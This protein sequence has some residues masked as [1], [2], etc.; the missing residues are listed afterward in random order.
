MEHHNMLHHGL[1]AACCKATPWARQVTS[2]NHKHQSSYLLHNDSLLHHIYMQLQENFLLWMLSKFS[3][4]DTTTHWTLILPIPL[5]EIMLNIPI[6]DEEQKFFKTSVRKQLVRQDTYGKWSSPRNSPSHSQQVESDGTPYIARGGSNILLAKFDD[7]FIL[8]GCFFWVS[9]P[10]DIWDVGG[11]G[12]I[13]SKPLGFTY[14]FTPAITTM[15]RCLPSFCLT[16]IT[17][18]KMCINLNLCK[19]NYIRRKDYA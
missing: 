11:N 19:L 2:V 16:Y 4:Y 15:C 9:G 14:G 10:R 12:I 18:F 6:E 7:D 17:H 3:A 8:S 1:A 5:K 13:T